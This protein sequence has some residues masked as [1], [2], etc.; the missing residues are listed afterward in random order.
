MGKEERGYLCLSESRLGFWKATLVQGEMPR[1]SGAGIG[2][3]L[4]FMP[5]SLSTRAELV[6]LYPQC[7]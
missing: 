3:G 6:H 1:S 2:R 4:H 7:T 5:S